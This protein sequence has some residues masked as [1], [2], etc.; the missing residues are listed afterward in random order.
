[1]G[2]VPSKDDYSASRNARINQIIQSDRLRDQRTVKL[3]LLGAGESGKSTILKQM[4]L[5]HGSG[6]TPQQRSAFKS[7]IFM[8]L[9]QCVHSVL[10]AMKKFD[11]QLKTPVPSIESIPFDSIRGYDSIPQ[12]LIDPISLCIKDPEFQYTITRSREYQL[13]DSA[14]YF[15]EAFDRLIKPDYIPTDQDILRIRVKSTGITESKFQLGHLTYKMFDVGGQR[16]ERRKWIHCFEHVTAILFLVGISEYDQV[17]E[18][19][20]RTNRM[21]ESL[22][23]F[24][25]IC[26]SQWFVNTSFIIFMNKIDILKRKIKTS[27]IQDFFPEFQGSNS[28]EEV[29]E[30]FLNKFLNKSRRPERVFAHFTCATDTR[31]ITFVMAAV[32]EIIIEDNLKRNGLL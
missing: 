9:L 4:Q 8:N 13:N 27:P 15:F 31:Q 22:I 23:L 20:S 29:A 5:I 2:C 12:E 18:E 26:N 25:L 11:L 7:Q 10:K 21:E 14:V 1:M 3:L 32:N 19:D 24:E 28:Y 17:L 6:F 16:S 30:F